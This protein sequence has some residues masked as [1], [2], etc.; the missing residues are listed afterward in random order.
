MGFI[1]P[2]DSEQWIRVGMALYSELGEQGF[3]P[4]NA[5]S[6]FGSSYDSKNIKSRWKTFR[7]GYGGRPVSIGTLIHYAINSGFKFDESKKEVSP[8][9]IQQRAERKK[10]LEIEAQEEQKKV[11]QGHASAKNQ[12]QQKWNN[13]VLCH[14]HSYLTKKDVMPHNTKLG[15]WAYNDEDGTLCT[16]ENALLVPLYKNGELVS[17]QG[18]LPNGYKE[19]L[20]KGEKQA[21]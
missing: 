17:M 1:D 10:L 6:S 14:S 8:H 19:L 21:V 9:I 18:I 5:W 20:Y 4:W 12:A 7:K 11:I 2:E 13:G 15:K 16:E 3:D